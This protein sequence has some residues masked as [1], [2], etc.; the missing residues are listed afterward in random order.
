MDSDG[1]AKYSPIRSLVIS[2]EAHVSVQPNPATDVAYFKVTLEKEA[3]IQ[4]QILDDL[5]RIVGA[6]ANDRFAA[7]NFD[8]AF[9][10]NQLTEGIYYYRLIGSNIE[11]TGRFSVNK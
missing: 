9:N 3:Q 6:V 4:L 10:L 2:G 11:E 5:G 8:L 1:S 7:G